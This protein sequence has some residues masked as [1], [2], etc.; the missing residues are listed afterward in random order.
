MYQ[1]VR[2][3][4]ANGFHVVVVAVLEPEFLRVAACGRNPCQCLAIDCRSMADERN[5][6]RG[7]GIDPSA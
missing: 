3:H 6:E 5:G 1:S 4:I 7:E 2:F